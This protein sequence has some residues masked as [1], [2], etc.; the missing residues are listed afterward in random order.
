MLH[1]NIQNFHQTLLS[2][3]SSFS[4]QTKTLLNRKKVFFTNMTSTGMKKF[5]DCHQ[6]KIGIEE[7]TIKLQ[8]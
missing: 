7:S 5:F 6:R 4:L 1:M 2:I 8:K 3:F